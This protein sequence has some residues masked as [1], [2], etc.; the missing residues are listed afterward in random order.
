M[1]KFIK[2]L[3]NVIDNFWLSMIQNIP[4]GFGIKLRYLY[5]KRKFKHCG[6][7]VLIDVGVVIQGAQWISVGNNVAIG[8][9]SVLVAGPVNEDGLRV[10]RIK[11]PDFR[12]KCGE[13]VIGD[14]V[15]ISQ[16]CIIQAHGG[17]E[18][19][20]NCGISAGTKIYSFSNLPRN[21]EVPSEEIFFNVFV[22]EK[23]YFVSGPIVIG[24]NVG[25]ALNSLVLPGVTIAKNSFVAIN[26]VVLTSFK[27]NSYIS[28][29]PAKRVEDRFIK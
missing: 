24:D 27:E 1:I 12:F 13:L 19:G 29:N 2:R 26:S 15:H 28:G 7:N 5:W 11:N 21:P 17:V 23:S 25:I 16:H 8:P 10:K 18:I 6:R 3:K 20:N 4:G 22:P 14:N 9:Y